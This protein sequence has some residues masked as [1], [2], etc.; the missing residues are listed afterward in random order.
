MAIIGDKRCTLRDN[1]LV[2]RSAHP[3]SQQ[4]SSVRCLWCAAF[5]VR[6]LLFATGS[7]KVQN[8]RSR[9]SAAVVVTSLHN[10]A[11]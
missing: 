1:P 8:A 9:F 10:T 6:T 11:H 4:E 5:I 2:A 7:T 3:V